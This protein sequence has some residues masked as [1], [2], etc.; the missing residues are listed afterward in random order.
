V[1]CLGRDK[2]G[3]PDYDFHKALEVRLYEVTEGVA[4]VPNEKGSVSG[5]ISVQSVADRKELTVKGDVDIDKVS[6]F[7][8]GRYITSGIDDECSWLTVKRE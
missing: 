6:V 3:K 4:N 2:T 7:E 8:G 1:L 5:S